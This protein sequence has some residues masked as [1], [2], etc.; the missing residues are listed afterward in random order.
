MFV[1]SFCRINKVL[2]YCKFGRFFSILIKGLWQDV[3]I[4]VYSKYTTKT[5]NH[6]YIVRV[7]YRQSV[8]LNSNH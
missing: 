2:L 1:L 6:T 7:K 8:Q 5:D 4:F 3:L